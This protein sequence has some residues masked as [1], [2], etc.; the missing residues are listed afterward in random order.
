MLLSAYRPWKIQNVSHVPNIIIDNTAASKRVVF[1][2]I[3][4]VFH[5]CNGKNRTQA[6]NIP[7]ARRS[8]LG[9]QR[10]SRRKKTQ[11]KNEDFHLFFG[12]AEFFENGLS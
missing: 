11:A 1:S 9:K 8:S 12:Y 10:L 3:V 5:H 7:H 2:E 6:H 4:E